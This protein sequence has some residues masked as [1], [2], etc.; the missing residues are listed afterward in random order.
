MRASVFLVGAVAVIGWGCATTVGGPR[1]PAQES[2][3]LALVAQARARIEDGKVTDGLQLFRRA[4]ELDPDSAE[5]AEEYGV[6]LAEAGVPGEATT[7]LRRARS[8]T[9]AGEALLGILLAQGGDDPEALAAAV[10]HL[11]AGL[12][13][14]P[15]GEHARFVLVQTLIRLGR[16]EAAL[17]SLQPLLADRPNDPR[18]QLMAGQALRLANRF[19]EAEEYLRRA[20]EAPVTRVRATIELVETLSAAQRFRE[21]ADV[22]GAFL[23]TEGATLE[24]LTRLATLRAR[25]GD[26]EGA[27]KVLDDVLARDEKF[28]DALVLRALMAATSNDVELAERLFRKALADNPDDLDAAMGLARVLLELRRLDEVRKLVASVWEKIENTPLASSA[29]GVDVA[30][31]MTTVELLDKRPDAARV[32]LDRTVAQPLG[33]RW[34]A[35]WAEYFRL[36]EA[37]EE[38]L[39]WLAG[40]AASEAS[41]HAQQ[42]QAMEAEFTLALGDE[43]RGMT[44]LAPL[45]AG[46]EDAVLDGL[47][48]LNRRKRYEKAIEA[49]R[50]ALERFPDNVD[51]RFA[52]AAALERSGAPEEAEK[53]FRA[54]LAK[55]PDNAQALNYLGYMFADRGVNL[56]EAKEMLE[57]AVA[58]DPTSAA[59]QDSLGWVY[60]RLGELG[61]A[62]K[63]LTRA[64]AMEPHDATVQEHLADLFGALGARERAADAY[65]RALELKPEEEGQRARIEAKLAEIAGAATP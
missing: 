14:F 27:M 49:S 62:E 18:F 50:A 42:R 2:E 44:L 26:K 64:A 22:L 25:A 3:A 12:S 17:G 8:L 65:R 47:D 11:E 23:Q 61:L 33:R 60:F 21:A 30:E 16:G 43:E 29:S 37:W 38:G 9:P 20:A 39:R 40:P 57:R 59:F 7:Q 41:E 6:A 4:V 32:W 52:L 54:V 63:H 36:R 28:R 56:A 31:A 48:V 15:Q 19:G 34:L 55:E 10:P 45:L 58:L 35:L 51:I 46:D 24:G 5:L 13:A 1:V 53:E